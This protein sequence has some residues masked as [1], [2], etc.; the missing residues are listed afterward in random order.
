MF[1]W[2]LTEESR[3]STCHDMAHMNLDH[4]VHQERPMLWNALIS[5]HG[6]M[7]FPRV[8]ESVAR[9]AWLCSWSAASTS[10]GEKRS[11]DFQQCSKHVASPWLVHHGS[12]T[13]VTANGWIVSWVMKAHSITSAER[14]WNRILITVQNHAKWL[15]YS[16]THVS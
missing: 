1:A 14:L 11:S 10:Q 16:S 12:S 7:P 15:F 4:H 6:Q 13:K 2:A 9:S 5:S 3:S 8:P